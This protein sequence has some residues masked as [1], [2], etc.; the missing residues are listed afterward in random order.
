MKIFD[1]IKNFFIYTPPDE[2]F[3]FSLKKDTS[4]AVFDVRAEKEE[5]PA[6]KISKDIEQ[7]RKYIE[8]R[9]NY[10]LNNDVIIRDLTLNG[11]I[12]IFLVFYDGMCNGKLINDNIIKPLLEIPLFVDEDRYDADIILE[13]LL[14]HSQSSKTCDFDSIIDNI[15]FGC[16]AIF[17]DGIAAAFSADVKDWPHRTVD[18]PEN[19]QSIYG[20]QEAF[21]EMLRGNSAQIRKFLKTEKLICE[22]TTIGN[23]SKTPGVIMYISDIA[24]EDLVNEVRRR[25]D[26]ISMDYVISIEEVSMMIEDNPMMI[27]GHILATERPDRVARALSEGRVALVLNASPRA[28]IFPTNAYEMTHAASDAFLR[29][30]FANMSRLI[31]LIAIFISVLLPGIFLAITMFHEE[32]LPT[33]LLYAISASRQNVPFPSVVELLLMEFSFEMI[34]EAGIRMPS[35]IGSILGIVGGLILGQAAVGAKIVSPIMI[36]IIAITGIGSFATADYSLGW[37]HRILKLIFILLGS[38]FGFFGIAMG[39]FIYSVLIASTTSFGIPFL[40]PLPGNKLY[41]EAVFV[42]PIWQ[43][44]KRPGYLKPKKDRREEKISK[45]WF[46]GR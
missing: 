6:P 36:I 41:K 14:T 18:K 46:V 30:D 43:T 5:P 19:E 22:K 38:S 27:T 15:N 37:S 7:N 31:R 32:M 10:P 17:V 42:P 26:G 16:C 44:E 45:K 8:S 34:R 23:I 39:I 2:N 4:G 9:F 24:N 1:K 21:A 13:T 3:Q 40:S 12:K 20:P 33:Y 25:L 29:P 11:D 35:P 28:L